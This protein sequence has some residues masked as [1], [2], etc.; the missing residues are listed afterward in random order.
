MAD[1]LSCAPVHQAVPE[2]EIDEEAAHVNQV[3]HHHDE[4]ITQLKSNLMLQDILK[5]AKDDEGYIEVCKLFEDR[6]SMP[7]GEKCPV[8]LKSFWNVRE[9]LSLED[10]LLFKDGRLV[11]LKGLR[12]CYLDNLIKLHQGCVKIAKRVRRSVWWPFMNKDVKALS[13]CC[14]SCV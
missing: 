10:G 2:D 14:K 7:P 9:E 6:K 13:H 5:A 11:I 1:T 4:E 12:Q 8:H 3:L